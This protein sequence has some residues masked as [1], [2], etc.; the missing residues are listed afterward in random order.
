MSVNFL[1]A[2]GNFKNTYLEWEPDWCYRPLSLSISTA[3]G[4]KRVARIPMDDEFAVLNVLAELG[5]GDL[6]F[7]LMSAEDGERD[8]KK[9]C[10][11]LYVVFCEV[12]ARCRRRCRGLELLYKES[13][14]CLSR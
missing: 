12:S 9:E 2:V 11:I 7:N 14:R 6:Q 10:S 4:V 1:V 3:E 8:A 13:S 5:V